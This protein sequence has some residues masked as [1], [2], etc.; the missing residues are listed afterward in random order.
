MKSAVIKAVHV[1]RFGQGAATA[2]TRRE[3]ARQQLSSSSMR[4]LAFTSVRSKAAQ[5]KCMAVA[6]SSPDSR[7]PPA[8]RL[9]R[10]ASVSISLDEGP[11]LT[12]KQLPSPKR[13]VPDHSRLSIRE[14]ALADQHPEPLVR[15]PST[16]ASYTPSHLAFP[17]DTLLHARRP[18]TVGGTPSLQ[19]HDYSKTTSAPV[20]RFM[21]DNPS[22]ASVAGSADLA[23]A[24]P[25]SSFATVLPPGQ[26]LEGREPTSSDSA[27]QP[28][29]GSAPAELWHAALSTADLRH[30]QD[31]EY[32][33]CSK[34]PSP[35]A[36]QGRHS[37]LTPNN[38]LCFAQADLTSSNSSSPSLSPRP[39]SLIID[40]VRDRKA[41]CAVA[42]SNSPRVTP[43]VVMR[44]RDLG[45]GRFHAQEFGDD[46]VEQVKDRCIV[47]AARLA[48]QNAAEAQEGL[49]ETA[50]MSKML[51]PHQVCTSFCM[52]CAQV[53]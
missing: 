37:C 33:T 17:P 40:S 48:S 35:D 26:A 43:R 34:S 28:Q 9:P 50:S 41:R 21:V 8:V 13:S 44:S 3:L 42:D 19:S 46:H 31:S 5:Q 7:T 11:P 52:A 36:T 22:T 23:A 30:L 49:S 14:T 51:R 25:G 24:A 4:R 2:Q 53:H 16:M 18:A 6:D 45:V 32:A 20:A 1:A 15:R 29:I 12:F 47:L 10:H 39:Q 38:M 27:M